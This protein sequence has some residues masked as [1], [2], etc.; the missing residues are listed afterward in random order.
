[1]PAEARVSIIIPVLN[2]GRAVGHLLECLD[3]VRRPGD[4]MIVVDGG[5]RDD[6]RE[7]ATEGA[8]RVLLSKQGRARQM[9]LGARSATGDLLWFLHAD[10]EVPADAIDRVRY[11]CGDRGWGRFDVRL[12]GR[13]VR[14]RLIGALMN[15]RSRASGIATGDQGIFVR[16]DLF[17]ALGG[18]SEIPLMEDIELSRRLRRRGRPACLRTCIVTSSRRWE[19][20]GVWRTVFLMWRLRLEYFLGQDPHLLARRYR[21]CSFPTRES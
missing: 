3:A 15:L 9:N 6:T 8:D 2:E 18:F 7:R 11:A 16:R 14:F 19:R 4:E 20:Y 5:S 10:S 12:S 17:E 13:G 1:V 21:E